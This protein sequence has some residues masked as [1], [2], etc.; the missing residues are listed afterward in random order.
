MPVIKRFAS[1]RL[2]INA[3]DHP[4]PHFHVLLN[5][6]REAW[7]RIDTLVIIHGRVASREIADAL[8]WAR[9]NREMLA[10]KFKEL[11]G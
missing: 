4:P 1:C 11:Q 8:D 7:V 5:D 6:E 2:R 10:E 9:E 3:K